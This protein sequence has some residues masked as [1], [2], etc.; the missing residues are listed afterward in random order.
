M[1]GWAGTA[2]EGL[3]RCGKQEGRCLLDLPREVLAVWS[4][5]WSELWNHKDWTRPE[6]RC[7]STAA[8]APG[9]LLALLLAAVQTWATPETF[10]CFQ[11][12]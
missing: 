10:S 7:G 12:D 6:G 1:V 9:S 2:L 3:S 11:A 5:Q 8:T 4:T